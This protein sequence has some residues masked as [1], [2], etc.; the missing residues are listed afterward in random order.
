MEIAAALILV[1]PRFNQ[2]MRWVLIACALC[3]VGVWIEKGLALIVP[4]FTP[5]PL[6]EVRAYVPTMTEVLV[7]LGLW[8]FGALV[9]TGLAKPAIAIQL[10]T[11]RR[12]APAQGENT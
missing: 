2:R 1:T 7:S 11:L 3:V 9:F 4:G 5:T 10:G 6:G 8:A 12:A